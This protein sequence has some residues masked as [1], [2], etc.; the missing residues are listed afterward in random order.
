MITLSTLPISTNQLYLGHKILTKKARENKRAIAWEASIQHRQ[1][2]YTGPIKV[3]VLMLWKDAR[4]HDLDNIKALLD[5][6]TNVVWEDDKQIVELLVRKG[7]DR[8]KPRCEVEIYD[9]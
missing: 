1:K 2:L 5:A 4:N 8:E 7:V 9:A 3:H 6:L